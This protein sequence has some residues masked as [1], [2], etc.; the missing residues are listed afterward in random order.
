MRKGQF[1]RWFRDCPGRELVHTRDYDLNWNVFFTSGLFHFIC[2]NI[3]IVC[4]ALST[5]ERRLAYTLS[6]CC[7]ALTEA[8]ADLL[9]CCF[10][11]AACF[12]LPFFSMRPLLKQ[13][14]RP[15][16]LQLTI[17]D[18]SAPVW[19]V[20]PS[21][22]WESP[23][24]LQPYTFSW[25]VVKMCFYRWERCIDLTFSRYVKQQPKNINFKPIWDA[26]AV[27]QQMRERNGR[28][29]AGRGS[30][31]T[32]RKVWTRHGLRVLERKISWGETSTNPATI[33]VP[34]VI[35]NRL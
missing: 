28:D 3:V 19:P 18:S 32:G 21:K 7:A 4:Q 16:H 30:E 26:V 12:L 17:D 27:T 5:A 6:T 25:N 22:S 31:Y 1:K 20:A 24:V 13:N 15:T 9:T 10:K 35:Q 33:W 11:Y 8:A 23:A 14:V 29:R 2:I 34:W